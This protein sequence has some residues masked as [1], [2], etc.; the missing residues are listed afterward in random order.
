MVKDG[1]LA[2]D[3]L[4]YF[5]AVVITI[6][7][8]SIVVFGLAS[9]QSEAAKVLS[10]LTEKSGILHIVTVASVVLVV[11]FLAVG[12]MLAGD[13]VT[14]ILSGIVGYVL[15]SLKSEKDTDGHA[16]ES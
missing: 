1:Q 2:T 6:G 5:T 16:R 4:K 15:G 11:F 3:I 13:G 9:R 8:T 7:V 10:N 12:G 14:S